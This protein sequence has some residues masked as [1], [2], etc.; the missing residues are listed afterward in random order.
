MTNE[1]PKITFD[2]FGNYFW[3]KLTGDRRGN[4][5]TLNRGVKTLN[6]DLPPP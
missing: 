1:A 4:I 3:Y 2:K 6:R 5:L